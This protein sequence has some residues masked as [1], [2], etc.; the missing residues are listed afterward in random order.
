MWRRREA[1]LSYIWNTYGNEDAYDIRPEFDGVIRTSP[2]TG[3]PEKYFPRW[4][5]WLRYLVS[6][7][8]TLPMLLVAVGAMLCSLNLNGYIKDKQSPIYVASLAYYAEPVSILQCQ[9][10]T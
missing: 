9:I 2:I 6:V 7:I 5:R 8:F 3:K 1:E 4:R 10:C